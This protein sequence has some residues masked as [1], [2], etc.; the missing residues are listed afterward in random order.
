MCPSA[1]RLSKKTKIDPSTPHKQTKL[2]RLLYAAVYAN[3]SAQ[4]RTSLLT[5]IH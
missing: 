5:L 4:R 1:V 3:F 2:R